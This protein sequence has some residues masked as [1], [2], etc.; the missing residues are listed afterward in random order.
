V[1]YLDTPAIVKLIR[2][3]AETADLH[4]WL[5]DNTDRT[6][7]TSVLAEIEVPRALRRADPSRMSAVPTILAKIN[8]IEIDA[9][10]RATAASYDDPELR[11]LDAIH[12]ASAHTLVLE[13]LRLRAFVTYDTRLAESV[14]R[15][16]LT[17]VSPGVRN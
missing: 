7:V 17:L 12:L 15:I 13:G 16:G 1:I 11:S 4:S 6:L 3:E 14:R 9:V 2:P 5:S 8:R 10:V